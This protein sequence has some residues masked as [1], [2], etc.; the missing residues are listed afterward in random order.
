[1]IPRLWYMPLL[2]LLVLAPIA[3]KK[4]TAGDTIINN[5]TNPTAPANFNA[6]AYAF[7]RQWGNTTGLGTLQNAN[8]I[9]LRGSMVFVADFNGGR[10]VEYSTTGEYMNSF[11]SDSL[12][13]FVHP[14]GV[15]LDR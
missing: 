7:D 6:L 10:V 15:A 2:I 4:T 8:G 11:T 12:G 13:A 9:A 3:C 5:I 14:Y 1:M